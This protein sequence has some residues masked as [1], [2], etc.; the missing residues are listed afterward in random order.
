MDEL[1]ETLT[2]IQT[3]KLDKKMPIILYGKEFWDD[4]INFDQFIN[5]GV[6]SPK[7]VD[8]FEIVDDLEEAFTMITSSLKD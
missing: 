7:D 3:K 5:W 8:L 1:F 6:I 4:L 2:L